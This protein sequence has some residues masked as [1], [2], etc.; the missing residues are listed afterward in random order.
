M[1]HFV[2]IFCLLAGWPAFGLAQRP[3]QHVFLTSPD[4]T[5]AEMAREEVMAVLATA[6]PDQP[7]DFTSQ[8]LSGLDFK[9][10][11][12]RLAR[13]NKTNLTNANLKGANLMRAELDGRISLE[14]VS[15]VPISLTPM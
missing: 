7:A 15:G 13:L 2:L 12:L 5:Q 4:M 10:A 11:V 1:K 3:L 9:Q 14:P 6:S 8:K